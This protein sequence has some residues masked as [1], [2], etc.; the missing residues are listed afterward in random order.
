M[1][2]FLYLLSEILIYVG[3]ILFVGAFVVFII[4]V[5]AKMA[6]IMI[7]GILCI[8]IGASLGGNSFE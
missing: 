8:L 6:I 1:K 7:A 5:F 3:I 2:K 4:K